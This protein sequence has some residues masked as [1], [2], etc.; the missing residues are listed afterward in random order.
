[1]LIELYIENF[2]LIDKMTVTFQR[3]LTILSGE[4]GAGKSIVIDAVNVLLGERAG[5]DLVRTGATRA[6]VQATFDL[7]HSPHLLSLLLDLGVEVED[8]LLTLAREVALEGRNLARINNRLTPLSILRQVGDLL[9]D[10]HGQHEHQSLLREE[11]HRDF[12]DALGNDAFRQLRTDVAQLAHRRQQLLHEQQ[13]LIS[14]ERDRLRAID[15]LA[16]Q[17]EEIEQAQL[18]IDEEEALA[19]ERLRLANA[20]KL[21][22][23]AALAYA[24]LYD[25]DE[26]RSVLDVLGEAQGRLETLT[27]VDD[28]LTS[29]AGLLESAAVQISE[30]CHELATYR[31]TVQFD[32]QRLE[33]LDTRLNLI[34]TLKRKYGESIAAILDYASERRDEWQ[35]LQRHEERRD[36]LQLELNR[37][38]AQ[39]SEQ[40]LTLSTQRARLATQLAGDM[41]QELQQLG[42]PKALFQVNLTR[43]PD[44]GGIVVEGDK[45]QITPAGI[46]A[47]AFHISANAGEPPKPLARVASGGELSRIMLALKAVSARGSEVPTLIFDEIDT[48]IGGRTAEAV[49]EKLSRVAQQVQVI[50]VTHL[51]QLAFYADNHFLIE[52]ATRDGRTTSSMRA[53]APDD[54]VNELARLQTGARVTDAVLTHIRAVLEEIERQKTGALF[55]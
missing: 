10:L 6:L 47:V 20:E 13:A 42:M 17:L 22:E 51:A 24:A 44:D 40:A 8:G 55:P 4:T 11:R 45:V 52:K 54:R 12:L 28:A 37:L 36:E 25:G 38:E 43:Q 50:A 29:L 18:T 14:D 31:D 33:E 9:V 5:T 34:N 32:P 2:A 26:G 35:R 19:A 30:A 16:F 23:A 1:M 39:L 48:G 53:L 15:L 46:D 41:Q 49:G 7:Q 27:R 21:H 3:G